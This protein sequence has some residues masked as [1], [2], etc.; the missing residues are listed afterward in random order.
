MPLSLYFK[1]DVVVENKM[2]TFSQHCVIKKNKASLKECHGFERNLKLRLME[3]ILL[4]ILLL[5]WYLEVFY[6]I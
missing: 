3:F 6:I 4:D 1:S 5:Y 2:V